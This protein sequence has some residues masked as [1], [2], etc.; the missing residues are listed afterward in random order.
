MRI[1]VPDADVVDRITILELKVRRLATGREAAQA[2]LDGLLADWRAQ[3][4]APL[5]SLHELSALRAVNEELWDVEEEL[6]AMERA[7]DFG[8][9]FVAR[10]RS[11]Y[12]LNDE[13][14]QLKRAINVATSSTLVEQKSY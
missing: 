4:A 10:A 2:E 9:E 13:R 1:D 12:H 14:A 11:V 3:G 5:E 7:G 8:P 6:R